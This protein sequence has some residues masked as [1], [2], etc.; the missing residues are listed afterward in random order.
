MKV[1]LIYLLISN[2][3]L[4]D[5]FLNSSATLKID[6]GEFT[7]IEEESIEHLLIHSE[8]KKNSIIIGSNMNLKCTEFPCEKYSV[9]DIEKI[10]IHRGERLI[11]TTREVSEALDP[12]PYLKDLRVKNA[13]INEHDVAILKFEKFNQEEMKILNIIR[14][15]NQKC[16]LVI[17]SDTE[18]CFWNLKNYI[19]GENFFDIYILKRVRGSQVY[20]VYDICAFCNSGRHIMKYYTKWKEGNGFINK[21]QFSSSFKGKF[22]GADLKVGL[23]MVD[24]YIFRVGISADGSPIYG[25]QTYWVLQFIAKA[26]D[27]NLVMLESVDE[28]FCHYTKKD[29]KFVELTGYCKMLASKEVTMACYPAA[30]SYWQYHFFDFTASYHIVYNRLVS[31]R[32]KM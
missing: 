28:E 11:N 19:L 16:F 26:A 13:G 1:V 12:F 17:F 30:M 18:E 10:L 8:P 4:G 20:L 31:A 24:P 2:L 6:T 14:E 9:T 25:G 23:V 5:C 15:Y 3:L 27:F 29:G 21:F 32:S 7:K 22:Y